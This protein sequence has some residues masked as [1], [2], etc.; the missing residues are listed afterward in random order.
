M[1]RQWIVRLLLLIA[2]GIIMCLFLIPI[3]SGASVNIG[4]ITGIFIALIFMLYGLLMRSWNQWIRDICQRRIG[5][6]VCHAV[7]ILIICITLLVSVETVLLIKAVNQAPSENANVVVLGC[8]V[9]GERPRLSMKQRLDAAYQYLMEKPD[10]I[11]ILS[12]VPIN[13][14]FIYRIE[15][16]TKKTR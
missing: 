7:D 5:R 11:C 1:K 2:G 8:R 4:G 3:R 9:Y 12:G 14:L 13:N 6:I 10:T 15:N 16:I